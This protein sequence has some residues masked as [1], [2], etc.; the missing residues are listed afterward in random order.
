M[1]L[2]LYGIGKVSCIRTAQVVLLFRGGILHSM[3]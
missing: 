3:V 2:P 1:T